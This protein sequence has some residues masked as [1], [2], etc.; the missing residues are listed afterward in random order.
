MSVASDRPH[1]ILIVTDQQRYDTVNRLGYPCVD[2]PNLD[3]MVDEGV[4]FAQCHVTA[5][6][7]VPSRASL[8]NGL[9][10]HTTGVL[11]NSD[12][13]SR[14]WV[15]SLNRAGYHC[16]NVGKMHTSPFDA[17]AGF[18]ERY[19]VENKER[20]T[21]FAGRYY[22]DQ[23]DVLLAANGLTR[24]EALNYRSR[25]DYQECLGAFE[26]PLDDHLH[27]DVFV[28]NLATWWLRTHR[29]RRSSDKPVFLQVGFPGPHPPYDPIRRYA[30]KYMARDIPLAPIE[31]RDLDGQPTPLRALR[32][33]MVGRQADSV[34]HQVKA[35]DEARH[36][37]RAFYLA[38]VEMIDE[39]IGRIYQALKANGYLENAVIVFTSDHGD[40]MTDHGQ[41]AK[42]TM[43]DEVTRVPMIV[44]GPRHFTKGHTVRSLVQH[45]DI[46]P[47]LLELAEVPRTEGME[48]ETLL[49]AL[50]GA[51]VGR[52]EVYC[53]QAGDFVL[54]GVGLM[55]MIRTQQWKLVHFSDS[56][57]GQLFDLESEDGER[58]NRWND[59]ECR[60]TRR[61][62]LERLTQWRASS[63]MRSS[64]WAADFR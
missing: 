54:Q 19:I 5:A 27:H 3:R 21:D 36:R 62:L 33:L 61:A 18:H 14:T 8:F 58:R 63:Q 6:T 13:W 24:S 30:E 31:D 7:C 34:V 16:V 57:E 44:W 51:D 50:Q 17:P 4:S 35:S 52:E 28:G 47:T 42:W 59:E 41:N 22:F 46:A 10:P 49:P 15:E 23:L 38:S 60:A 43:F 11:R 2:T 32:E 56:E 20:R 48:A 64:K 39:Q 40:T 1:I 55:T 53:E 37:Q 25:P 29:E 26:F 12:N 45:F 9:Y